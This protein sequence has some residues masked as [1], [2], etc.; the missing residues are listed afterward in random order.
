MDKKT[1]VLDSSVELLLWGPFVLVVGAQPVR[2][3]ICTLTAEEAA[4]QAAAIN[5]EPSVR[6][7]RGV[8]SLQENRDVPPRGWRKWRPLEI[9]TFRGLPREVA[10]VEKT[11]TTFKRLVVRDGRETW[12]VWEEEVRSSHPFREDDVG[13]YMATQLGDPAAAGWQW[14]LERGFVREF[15]R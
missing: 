4:A 1:V 12:T 2:G 6:A 11:G 9:A 8:R 3:G 14:D 10:V 7:A 15:P 13:A 5:A